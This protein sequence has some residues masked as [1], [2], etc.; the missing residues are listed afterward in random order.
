MKFNDKKVYK[1]EVTIYKDYGD[2]KE[3]HHK[4]HNVVVSGLGE[5]IAEV[6]SNEEGTLPNINAF[7]LG[8]SGTS[9]LEVSTTNKLGSSLVLSSYGIDEST[10]LIKGSQKINKVLLG[11]YFLT[12]D[13]SNVII[14]DDN[15]I[16]LSLVVGKNIANGITI[17]EVGMFSKVVPTVDIY[18]L[19]AYKSFPSITKQAEYSLIFEWKLYL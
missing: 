17:D 15:A 5:V 11:T 13:Q 4:D 8:A 9:S 16:K 18:S 10:L 6:M 14:T 19:V 7:Q 2:T 1:G 12:I 3:L